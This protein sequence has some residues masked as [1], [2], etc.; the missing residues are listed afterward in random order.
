VALVASVEELTLEAGYAH[1]PL[2]GAPDD[3]TTAVTEAFGLLRDVLSPGMRLREL[4]AG[5]MPY[6]WYLEAAVE[7]TWHTE[8][9]M[10]LLLWNFFGR[11]SERI[12]QNDHLPARPPFA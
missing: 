2:A 5:R 1:F 7:G 9:M 8:Q 6:R 12:Y 3:P 4:R 11:R 10:G